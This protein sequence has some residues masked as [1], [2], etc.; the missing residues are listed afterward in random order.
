MH[1]IG[2]TALHGQWSECAGVQ[3]GAVGPEVQQARRLAA[4]RLGCT[5]AAGQ[6]LRPG[7]VRA[8]SL[9]FSNFDDLNR[10]ERYD[11]VGSYDQ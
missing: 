3:S 7:Q 8:F 2:G 6:T 4:A 5:A 1:D 11:T 10:I 9:R